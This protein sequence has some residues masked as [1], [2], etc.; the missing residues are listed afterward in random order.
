MEENLKE[1]LDYYEKLLTSQPYLTSHVR[2]HADLLA[3]TELTGL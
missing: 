2:L 1:A 3:N